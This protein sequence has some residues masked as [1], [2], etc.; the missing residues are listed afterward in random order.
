MRRVAWWLLL[1]TL[2]LLPY[3]YW[4]PGLALGRFTITT[5]E[6]VWM[7]AIACWLAATVVSRRRPRLPRG[8]PVAFGL[9]LAVG[10]TS[11]AL[12]DG[13]NADA[14]VFVGRSAAGWLLCLAIADMVRDERSM[15]SALGAIL[16]GASVSALIG[17]AL[18]AFPDM[19][20]VLHIERFFTIGVPRLTGTFDYPNTAAMAFEASALLGVALVALETRRALVCAEIAAIGVIVVAMTLTLSRGAAVGAAVGLVAIAG[21]AVLSRRPRLGAALAVS[22][23]TVAAFAIVVQVSVAPVERLFTDAERGLYG[24]TYAAPT[25]VVLTDGTASVTVN[26]TNTGSLTWNDGGTADYALGYHWLSPGTTDVLA[27]GAQRVEVGTVVPGQSTQVTV[28]IAAP[29]PGTQAEVAWDMVRGSWGWFSMRGVP[30]SATRLGVGAVPGAD[31]GSGANTLVLYADEVGPTRSQLWSVAL[32]M[33]TERPLLGVGPGTYRLRY[34]GY[35]GISGGVETHANNMYLE[36]GATTGLIGLIVFLAV[37]GLAT[38]PLVRVLARRRPTDGGGPELS[39]R[40]WIALA[41][42]L[43][44]VVAF[45][46]HGL[47]DYFLAFNPTGG[48]WWATLGLAAAAGWPAVVRGRAPGEVAAHDASLT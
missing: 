33:I 43:A 36:I 24:A 22:A 17:L 45:L 34:D 2:V 16:T 7:A 20:N 15:R 28:T 14:F 26:L 11:A 46:A 48:L 29:A 27:D 35:A 5:L 23:V 21:L 8:L 40:A 19:T 42:I 10:V 12:A 13:D 1:L 30:V 38:L 47:I 6:A 3:E 25:A 44:A 41:A 9:L 37:V 31:S 18:L 4:L 39:S 32:Q